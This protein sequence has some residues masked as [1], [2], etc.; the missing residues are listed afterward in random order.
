MNDW[1]KKVM[2]ANQCDS[3]YYKMVMCTPELAAELLLLNTRNR[4]R[5]VVA[6]KKCCQELES[7]EWCATNEGVGI[8]ETGILL[9][10][11]HRLMAIVETGIT[12]PLLIVWGLP[13][14]S[15]E[16]INCGL[17]RSLV[18]R[19]QWDGCTYSTK[20]VGA[21]RVIASMA[22]A[23]VSDAKIKEVYNNLAP[24]LE[25]AAK[26]SRCYPCDK[27]SYTAALARLARYSLKSATDFNEK[28]INPTMIEADDPRY[29]LNRWL[30][31]IT[32][33]GAGGTMQA[34]IYKST[35][36]CI[37]KFLAGEKITSVKK[38]DNL[39]ITGS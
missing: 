11:Q 16:K 1:I 26:I 13:E 7:G 18:Q 37:N 4:P 28:V 34:A 24:E 35:M 6:V 5:S 9:D 36:Y 2:N 22:N 19:L 29:R 10:G 25:W 3:I 12:A 32:G 17:R 38:A 20:A 30:I 31:T 33:H 23:I 39:I 15:Q 21:A 8:S 27:V 14:K